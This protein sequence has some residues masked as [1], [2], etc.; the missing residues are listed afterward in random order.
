MGSIRLTLPRIF[1]EDHHVGRDCS[2]DARVIKET[3][4]T[5]TVDLTPNDYDDIKSDAE[6]YAFGGIDFCGKKAAY[7]SLIDSARATVRAIKRQ[8]SVVCPTYRQ[9]SPP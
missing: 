3:S 7:R 6:H 5:V 8:S 9:M 2:P 4:K 1:W